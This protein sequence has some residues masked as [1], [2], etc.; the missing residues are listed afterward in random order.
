MRVGCECGGAFHEGAG[1][2]VFARVARTVRGH[3]EPRRQP[4]AG[5][6][7]GGAV[8]P[9]AARLLTLTAQDARKKLMDLAPVR[10]A[11]RLVRGDPGPRVPED[12]PVGRGM[13]EP[14]RLGGVERPGV[15]PGRGDGAQVGVGGHRVLVG[16]REEQEEAG[17]VGQG[18]DFLAVRA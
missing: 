4:A 16:R 8:V 2:G 13:G 12:D 17:A 11:D 6:E 10:R 3:S 1:E 14:G 18:A 5:A 7:R 9:G 15:D